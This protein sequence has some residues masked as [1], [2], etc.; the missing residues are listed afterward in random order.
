MMSDTQ[1]IN[2]QQV[3]DYLKQHPSFFKEHAALLC[4][5]DISGDKGTP[6]HERQIKA[7]QERENQQQT[8]IDFIVDNAK[9]NQRLESDL[10]AVAIHLLGKQD[11]NDSVETI[12]ALIKRQFN[13]HDVIVLLD[14]PHDAC[15]HA[16]YD[17]VRQRVAHH[18]SICDDRVASNLLVALF[19]QNFK[20]IKSCAFV[21][22]VF[23]D[24][25]NGIMVL[26]SSS[27]TR[28][29]A[30]IGVVFLDRLGRLIGGYL[31]GRK[32]NS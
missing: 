4:N 30:G 3:I 21:P 25:I 1:T 28:F 24:E 13:V 2:T 23:A 22:L 8:S 6:F 19:S 27:A 9:N 20:T 18:S 11:G 32:S 14:N 29:Q 17:D 5:L 12:S 31:Q 26:G 10:L 16:K 15:R 7:L